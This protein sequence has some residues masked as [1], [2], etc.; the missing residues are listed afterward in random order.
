MTKYKN[1]VIGFQRTDNQPLEADVVFP[2]LDTLSTYLTGKTKY[3]GQ[4]LTVAGNGTNT[5][6]TAYRVDQFNDRYSI[7]ALCDLSD[8]VLTTDPRLSNAR[9]ASDVYAWAK[10]A[11]KPSYNYSEIAGELYRLGSKEAL[12]ADANTLFEDYV[13]RVYSQITREGSTNMF[14]AINNANTILSIPTHPGYSQQL[15]F[16]SNGNIYHRIRHAG[17]FQPTWRQLA[18]QDWVTDTALSNFM[19]LSSDQT[20][21]GKK[22]FEYANAN[23]SIGTPIVYKGAISIYNTALLGASL[24]DF[25]GTAIVMIGQEPKKKLGSIGLNFD[26]PVFVDSDNKLFSILH[27]GS[28]NTYAPSLTGAGANGTWNINI[29]GYA[30]ISEKLKTPRNLWGNSFNGSADISGVIEASK[31]IILPYDGVSWYDMPRTLNCIRT[32]IPNNS[33]GAAHVLYRV[34]SFSGS[35]AAFGGRGDAIGFYGFTKETIDTGKNAPNWDT[36]WNVDTGMLTHT[37]NMYIIGGLT[38]ATIKADVFMGA[39]DGN[40]STATKWQT[41]RT[42]TLGGAINGVVSLDGGSNVILN[43]TLNTSVFDGRYVQKSGDRID[44]ILSVNSTLIVTNSIFLGEDIIPLKVPNSS[45]NHN[46]GNAQDRFGTLY[47]NAVDVNGDVLAT[48]FKRQ[49]G[50]A[51][52]LLRA[53]GGITVFNSRMIEGHPQGVWGSN[54]GDWDVYN[55]SNFS[56]DSATRLTTTRYIFGNAFDGSTDISGTLTGVRDIVFTASTGVDIGTEDGQGSITFHDVIQGL[57]YGNGQHTWGID[58]QTGSA[59]LGTITPLGNSTLGRATNKWQDIYCVNLHPDNFVLNSISIPS[60]GTLSVAGVSTFSG[61]VNIN[62]LSIVANNKPIHFGGSS[63]YR[64]SIGYDY[65][66]DIFCMSTTKLAINFYTNRASTDNWDGFSSLTPALSLDSANRL[67]L[68]YTSSNSSFRIVDG[69]KTMVFGINIP[70]YTAADG[71]GAKTALV[72]TLARGSSIIFQSD[73]GYS[74]LSLNPTNLVFNG[75]IISGTGASDIRLKKDITTFKA[76][77]ILRQLNPIKYHWTDEGLSLSTVLSNDNYSY[78]LSAQDTLDV[79]PQAVH[80]NVIGNKYMAIDYER[81]V[82]LLIGGYQELGNTIDVLTKEEKT[83]RLIIATILEVMGRYNLHDG[84]KE[85]IEEAIHVL[86]E[87]R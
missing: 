86:N 14:P 54:G 28:I 1:T 26:N 57:N 41:A 74:V 30:A 6:G 48:S 23:V 45:S 20:I 46:L 25:Y 75:D 51:S 78:G 68:T 58:S 3:N 65:S 60:T 9:V 37:A 13:F 32:A 4:L 80:L 35:V 36:T 19:D 17:T 5:K 52:Q 22:E 82:P 12:I 64:G 29:N 53:D 21:T 42:I 11:V 72:K 55:P 67:D 84:D 47:A 39:L 7:N 33:V 62:G 16:S 15:G 50:T 43:N 27:S 70:Y 31:G 87:R 76:K 10:A 24:I 61:N 56:V 71:Y 38:A 66:N 63:S 40:A 2:N 77:D 83:H 59:I 44:G 34:E 18:F 73:G 85:K 69:S 79:F 49:G 81:F 8:A